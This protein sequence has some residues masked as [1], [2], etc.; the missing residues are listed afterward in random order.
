MP[1]GL[2]QNRQGLGWLQGFRV[3]ALQRWINCLCI[4]RIERTRQLGKAS[5][6]QSLREFGGGGAAAAPG[7]Q[8]RLKLEEANEFQSVR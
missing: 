3:E 5:G 2:R 4:G 1:A 6:H 8:L 7:K